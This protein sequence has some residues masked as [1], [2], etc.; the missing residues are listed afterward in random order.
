MQDLTPLFEKRIG[1]LF[2][3]GSSMATGLANVC[4]PAIAE[5]TD[6]VTAK[7]EE[8]KWCQIPLRNAAFAVTR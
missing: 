1:F 3:A 8:K 7:V 2:G 6:L 5:M 4:V